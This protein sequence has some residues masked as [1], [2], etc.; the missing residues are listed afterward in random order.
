MRERRG[1]IVTLGILA[2]LGAAVVLIWFQPQTL[3]INREVTDE[4][5]DS[6]AGEEAE[7]ASGEFR[8]LSHPTTGRAVIRQTGDAA[9]LRFENLQTD[10]GPDLRVYLS[11][12]QAGAPADTFDDDFIDLGP[13]K[14]NTGDQNYDI[15]AGVD[16][17]L[18]SSAVIWCRRFSV[19]FGVAPLDP[20]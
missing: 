17:S 2:V 14:G 6:M 19:G 16:P 15:P 5:P 10:N 11:T 7:L 13:L 12:A 1:M 9:L 4:L 3:L 18:Y 8:D 20:A